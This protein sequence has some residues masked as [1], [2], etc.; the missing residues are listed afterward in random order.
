MDAADA[1][2]SDGVMLAFIPRD[3][4]WTRV[5]YPHMTLVYAG[6]KSDLTP[7]D[8]SSLAK[9]AATVALLMHPF[10][11]KS[12]GTAVFGD[13]GE[14]VNVLRLRPTPELLAVRQIVERWNASKH[15]FNPH[16]TIGS[17]TQFPDPQPFAIYF[18]RLVLAWGDDKIVFSLR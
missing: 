14:Q 2:V 11:L 7:S 13:P 5:D 16:V 3:D 6:T 15:D 17:A 10:S 18:D 4:E 8:F 12:L 1:P 9:D